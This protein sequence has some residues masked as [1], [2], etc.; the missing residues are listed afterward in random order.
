MYWVSKLLSKHENQHLNSDQHLADIV[1]RVLVIAVFCS[2]S[3]AF[4]GA[5]EITS[6]PNELN[7]LGDDTVTIDDTD[8]SS[9]NGKGAEV[10][11][12]DSDS[13]LAI[14]LWD[15]GRQGNKGGTHHEMSSRP[16]I[17]LTVIQK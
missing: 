17:T 3:L 14:I 7:W 9:I 8:L 2:S 11:A 6:E 10:T 4:A 16:V 5:T 1:V 15:E 12:L 13:K